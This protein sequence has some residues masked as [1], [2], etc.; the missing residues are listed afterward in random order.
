M[1]P[2]APD[3]GDGDKPALRRRLRA[4]RAAFTASLSGDAHAA[5]LTALA[6]RLLDRIGHARTIAA[7]VA[8]GD[9]IDPRPF[10]DA[11]DARGLVVALPCIA[12]REAPMIFRRWRPGAT[13]AAGALGIPEP[14]PDS[15]AV[16]PDLILAPLVGFDRAGGRLGQGAG[17]YDRAFA[18]LPDARRIGLAWGVQEVANLP[19]DP[20]DVPLHV[21]ATESEWINA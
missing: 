15:P 7:Y 6:G 17:F 11:A 12:S 1:S 10:I 9:E 20:W 19:L 8:M 2:F 21:V 13:L 4:R 5:H 18:G 3:P 16:T 14:S